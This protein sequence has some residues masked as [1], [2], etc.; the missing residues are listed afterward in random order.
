VVS[1]RTDKIAHAVQMAGWPTPVVNDT[2]GS[3]YAYSQGNHDKKVLKLPG[4]ADQAGWATPTTVDKAR[5]ETFQKGRELN[6]REL[7]LRGEQ[8]GPA[9]IT[10]SGEMLTGS[11]AG[12]ESG[13]QLDP[14]HS[15]WLMGYPPEW[16]DCAVMATPSSR[17]RAPRS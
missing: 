4:A 9:R 5:S 11:F 1:G 16:C 8:V 12:M 14:A 10:S 7:F 2:T 15:R 3:K 6:A 17:K 13:G